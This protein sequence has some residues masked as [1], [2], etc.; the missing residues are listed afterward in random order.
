MAKKTRDLYT[1]GISG[2]ELG[3]RVAAHEIFEEI[4]HG[5]QGGQPGV[6]FRVFRDGFGATLKRESIPTGSNKGQGGAYN[7]TPENPTR[8]ITLS[9]SRTNDKSIYYDGKLIGV[10]NTATCGNHKYYRFEN[11]AKDDPVF[12]R[13]LE[14]VLNIFNAAKCPLTKKVG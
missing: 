6:F 13:F 14:D 2:K 7:A 4:Y 3:R 1:K 12:A 11:D 5:V 8:L 10:W 9:I